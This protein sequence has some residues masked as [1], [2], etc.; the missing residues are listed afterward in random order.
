MDNV[1][2]FTLYC[3]LLTLTSQLSALFRDRIR[4]CNILMTSW[5]F[6]FDSS[7]D[8]VSTPISSTNNYCVSSSALEPMAMY[9]KRIDSFVLS[10]FAPSAILLGTETVARRIYVV[11]P[12][13]SSSGNPFVIR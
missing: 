12:F 13:F 3:L 4:P 11:R 1:Y 8:L 6:S 9:R 7:I 10:G 2:L 5:S